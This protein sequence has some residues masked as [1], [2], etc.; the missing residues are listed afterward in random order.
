MQWKSKG[1]RGASN[2]HSRNDSTDQTTEDR[3]RCRLPVRSDGPSGSIPVLG[4]II[5]DA[6]SPEKPKNNNGPNDKAHPRTRLRITPKTPPRARM[7]LRMWGGGAPTRC[8]ASPRAHR[9]PCATRDPPPAPPP[10]LRRCCPGR[11]RACSPWATRFCSRSPRSSPTRPLG[12]TSWARICPSPGLRYAPCPVPGAAR[13]GALGAGGGG[14]G[15]EVCNFP[16]FF[17]MPNYPQFS[18][19]FRKFLQFS[20]IFGP[21]CKFP[22]FFAFCRNIPLFSAIFSRNFPRF[23]FG[24]PRSVLGCAANFWGCRGVLFLPVPHYFHAAAHKLDNTVHLPSVHAS[25]AR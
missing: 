22:Q 16:H 25:I 23:V 24:C 2:L 11:G 9:T 5:R 21:F 3:H 17:A 10:H 19:V 1:A 18:A 7:A 20:A 14:G 12:C 15:A 13:V 8:H 4:A 6:R